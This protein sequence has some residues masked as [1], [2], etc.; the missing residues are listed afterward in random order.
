MN[1]WQQI[2]VRSLNYSY[3]SVVLDPVGEWLNAW[4]FQPPAYCAKGPD[5]DGWKSFVVGRVYQDAEGFLAM[6]F[7]CEW[8]LSDGWH[9]TWKPSGKRCADLGAAMRFCESD[10]RRTGVLCP[11]EVYAQ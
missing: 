9:R 2:D 11:E 8:K 10:F 1:G 4:E 7:G 3:P 6:P 5:H